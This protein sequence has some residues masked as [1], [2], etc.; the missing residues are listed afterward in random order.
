M[1]PLAGLHRR[2]FH[3][4]FYFLA[5]FEFFYQKRHCNVSPSVLEWI[6]NDIAPPK[7]CLFLRAKRRSV[8]DSGY[9]TSQRPR[10]RAYEIGFALQIPKNREHVSRFFDS[11]RE[12]SFCTETFFRPCFAKS[13]HVL[14]EKRQFFRQILRHR[15]IGAS[16]GEGMTAADAPQCKPASLKCA[17]LLNRLKGVLRAGRRIATAG[18]FERREIL[19]VE[20]HERQK[21]PLHG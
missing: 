1:H 19:P 9:P 10:D 12:K 13:K 21:Q 5:K 7:Q 15:V 3:G 20:P 8:L 2:F 14:S 16:F 18:R 11:E 4:F 6:I 17:V